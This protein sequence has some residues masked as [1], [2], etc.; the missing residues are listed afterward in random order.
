MRKIP[1]HEKV[2]WYV[3][4]LPAFVLAAVVGHT[5]GQ[6]IERGAL[7]NYLLYWSASMP[8][9]STPFLLSVHR[10]ADRYT[11][12]MVRENK[13]PPVAPKFVSALENNIQHLSPKYIAQQTGKATLKISAEAVVGYAFGYLA[14]KYMS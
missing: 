10:S 3:L 12:R 8:V 9:L 1:D 13:I 14:G 7:E 5:D 11:L 4:D 6:G 2:P